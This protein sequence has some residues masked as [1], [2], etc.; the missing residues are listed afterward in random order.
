MANKALPFALDGQRLSHRYKCL[1]G[2]ASVKILLVHGRNLVGK[3]PEQLQVQWLAA[4]QRGCSAAGIGAPP[5]EAYAMPFYGDRFETL[6]EGVDAPLAEEI[7]VRDPDTI[8]PRYLEFRRDF[9]EEIRSGAGITDLQISSELELLG[10]EGA[11]NRVQCAQAA[12]QALDKYMP[13]L[14][15]GALDGYAR[16]VWAYLATPHIRNEIDRL[17]GT[18]MGA[19]P[20]LLVGHS[21]GSLIAYSI[22]RRV[23]SC[24]APRLVTLGSPLG[25]ATVRNHF[26]PLNFPDGVRHWFN[27][28]DQR[29]L[30]ALRGLGTEVF[31]VQPPVHNEKDLVNQ[32]RNFHGAE[33]YLET[34]AVA[35]A[36]VELD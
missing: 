23:H 13:R 1:L 5:D 11:P 19:E 32:T 6:L 2:S 9:F 31:P 26:R 8:D 17:V 28:Y 29:D 14:T 22:L 30:V 20:T 35:R 27:G 7:A 18:G 34:P 3:D 10:A 16:D 12:L 24:V 25:L 15:D 21:L 4:I 36:L 33:G